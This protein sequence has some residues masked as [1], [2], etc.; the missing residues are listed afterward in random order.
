MVCFCNNVVLATMKMYW[1]TR[2]HVIHFCFYV[3]NSQWNVYIVNECTEHKPCYHTHG[4]FQLMKMQCDTIVTSWNLYVGRGRLAQWQGAG[5]PIDGSQAKY[6]AICSK[7]LP[8]AEIHFKLSICNSA[9][10]K[11]NAA[12]IAVF[13]N[14]LLPDQPEEHI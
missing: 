3:K 8:L 13:G 5:T 14:S 6:P 11:D 7:S 10:V 9:D 2:A 12:S 1:V 4:L